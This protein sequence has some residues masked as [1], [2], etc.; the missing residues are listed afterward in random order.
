M[1]FTMLWL[2]PH[3]MFCLAKKCIMQYFLLSSLM[4]LIPDNFRSHRSRPITPFFS[5]FFLTFSEATDWSSQVTATYP[6]IKCHSP[7][8]RVQERRA[9]W[10]Q[11][12][13]WPQ[14]PDLGDHRKSLRYCQVCK[15][16]GHLFS[17]KEFTVKPHTRNAPLKKK[18]NKNIL[19]LLQL[20]PVISM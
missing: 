5:S 18:A 7:P 15:A 19:F 14:R 6:G 9:L 17:V 10:P 20:T 8:H 13:P 11:R 4:N 2:V 1:K 12:D 3:S 16:A